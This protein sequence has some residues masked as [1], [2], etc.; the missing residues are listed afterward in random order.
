MKNDYETK[1]QEAVV[2]AS[3]QQYCDVND[4]TTCE[5][6]VTTRNQMSP[7]SSA[8][9]I[10][11]DMTQ[12]KDSKKMCDINSTVEKDDNIK[13]NWTVEKSKNSD[14]SNINIKKISDIVNTD[15]EVIT[16]DSAEEDNGIRAVNNP[17]PLSKTDNNKTSEHEQTCMAQNNNVNNTNKW[18]RNADID[19]LSS[20][21]NGTIV[22]LENHSTEEG[23]TEECNQSTVDK[24][25]RRMLLVLPDSDSDYEGYLNNMCPRLEEEQF[26]IHETLHLTLEEAFFLSFGLGCLQVIDL[27]GNCLSL[28][29]MWQLFCKSQKDFIQKYVTYHYFR[30][31][32]WVVKPG[33]KFGGDFCKLYFDMNF[34][35]P[36]DNACYENIYVCACTCIHG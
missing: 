22:T 30:S 24:T 16:L 15:E 21:E 12:E 2:N 8:N 25:G 29:G 6:T 9:I 34:I 27:F 10:P 5:V 3:S 26:P 33:I 31:K 35:F 11:E 18:K 4:K 19:C 7:K 20:N 32:G 36:V 17:A 13:T 23:S 1:Q 14:G 28:N